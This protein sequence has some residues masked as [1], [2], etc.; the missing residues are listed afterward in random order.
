M[1]RDHS[2]AV[3]GRVGVSGSFY[4]PREGDL[5]RCWGPFELGSPVV[6]LV[7]VYPFRGSAR[8][9]AHREGFLVPP[10]G[11]GDNQSSGLLG[12]TL[13]LGHV[14]VCRFSPCHIRSG[15]DQQMKESQ[16]TSPNPYQASA[17]NGQKACERNRFAHVN[18]RRSATP[19]LFLNCSSDVESGYASQPS[20]SGCEPVLESRHA[21]RASGAAAG[22]MD[23]SNRAPKN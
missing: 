9:R 16:T 19:S 1:V 4:P 3:L 11:C 12:G 7:V 10:Y 21:D 23:T 17:V 13:D 5:R 20:Q 2:P 18:V 8:H 14:H 15:C 22:S 6:P